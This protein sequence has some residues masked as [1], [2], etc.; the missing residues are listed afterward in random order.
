M[1]VYH[2]NAGHINL[3]E[4]NKKT[5]FDRGSVWSKFWGSPGPNINLWWKIGFPDSKINFNEQRSGNPKIVAR[6]SLSSANKLF[7]FFPPGVSESSLVSLRTTGWRPYHEYQWISKEFHG[8]LW[9][10]MDINVY[11]CVSKEFLFPG[12]STPK[13]VLFALSRKF[14]IKV[15]IAVKET[16]KRITYESGSCI[17]FVSVPGVPE[18]FGLRTCRGFE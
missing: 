9:I 5:Y 7:V 1:M 16:Q 3:K 15:P 10:P 18:S 4:D 14:F 12:C 11:L 13:K 6:S 2:R 8:Y 17:P